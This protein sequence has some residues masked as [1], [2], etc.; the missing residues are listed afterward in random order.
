MYVYALCLYILYHILVSGG[1]GGLYLNTTSVP[2]SLLQNTPQAGA[3]ETFPM[4]VI[5]AILCLG[6]IKTM[7]STGCAMANVKTL[8]VH[9]DCQS[10]CAE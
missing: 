10:A 5:G 2:R 4:H 7:P 6:L 1:G 3:W 9:A 8:T